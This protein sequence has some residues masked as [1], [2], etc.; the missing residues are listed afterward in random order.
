MTNQIKWETS[1]SVCRVTGKDSMVVEF[2]GN[3][4]LNVLVRQGLQFVPRL[5]P[6]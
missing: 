1:N 5:Q 6:I 4:F 2:V 3:A